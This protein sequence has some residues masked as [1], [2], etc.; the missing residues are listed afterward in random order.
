MSLARFL[1]ACT[2]SSAVVGCAFLAVHLHDARDSATDVRP[3]Q[4]QVADIGARASSTPVA[5]PSVTGTRLPLTR[6]TFDAGQVVTVVAH[7]S[8][9]SVATLQ[10]WRKAA[11][12]GWIKRGP[13]IRA[14]IGSQGIS[15]YASESKS[16]TP[17]GS[18]SL[19]R[20]FGY[21]ANPGIK[22]RWFRSTPSDWWISQSGPL[23]NTH[24]R[25]ASG[26]R[27]AQGSP[28]EHLY[29]ERPYYAYAAVIDYN[30]RNS[31]T[32][33][34]QGRGSAFFLHV[35]DGAATAGCVA[36]P[37]RRLVELLTWLNPARHPR[38]L[39]GVA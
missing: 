22:L 10:A 35:T 30:T 29:Y 31:A 39:I 24:Q 33:V 14:H 19:T 9:S 25:C 38:I 13:A 4:R 23:Y 1:A 26:C 15:R 17:A 36:I 6:R 2:A 34:R 16:A 28:N 7:S 20:A 11:G 12:G 8:T 5:S 27:F 21:R 32:G 18:F 37:Q 3:T